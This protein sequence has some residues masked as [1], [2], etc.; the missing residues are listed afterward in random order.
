MLAGDPVWLR[1]RPDQR[2]RSSLGKTLG[3]RMDGISVK[4]PFPLGSLVLDPRDQVT[5]QKRRH[6]RGG[7]ALIHI[8]WAMSVLCL[9]SATNNVSSPSP[10]FLCISESP[11]NHNV[12][13]PVASLN[14]HLTL[15]PNPSPQKTL[16]LHHRIN[17]KAWRN[18]LLGRQ[19]GLGWVCHPEWVILSAGVVMLK[20]KTEDLMPQALALNTLS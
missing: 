14:Q 9:H 11:Q 4:K 17:R 3:L 10:P 2:Q 7:H 1:R 5:T 20:K 12:T 16:E 8:H 18:L 15:L 6:E 13:R 19:R